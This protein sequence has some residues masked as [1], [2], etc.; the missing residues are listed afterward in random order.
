MRM[1]GADQ[2]TE[3]CA[4]TSATLWIGAISFEQRCLG[5]VMTLREAGAHVKA[6][7][8][9]D[10]STNMTPREIGE[11]RRQEHWLQMQGA[12]DGVIRGRFER[13]AVEPYSYSDIQRSLKE[14]TDKQQPDTVV[15]DVSCMTKIHALA[16]GSWLV[17]HCQSA[18]IIISYT[19]PLHFGNL[20]EM[21]RRM[22]W[23]DIVII[24][25]VDNAEL[26]NEYASRGIIVLGHE[27]DRL[28]VA[29][30]E[31]HP[32][33][34]TI[35][36]PWA[37]RRPDL[38]VVANRNNRK[39]VKELEG[40]GGGRWISREARLSEVDGLM[41]MVDREVGLAAK[42]EAPLIVFPFGPKLLLLAISYRLRQT[43]ERRTWL[44]YPVPTGYDV[45]YS[46]GIDTVRWMAIK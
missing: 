2:V 27:N 30:S 1:L 12:A 36:T 41:E 16:I 34:G 6:G 10:Y 38:R 35:V 17:T 40:L 5:G 26:M 11:V 7:I 28:I 22:G 18:N 37:P 46:E 23:K 19:S 14:V 20:V 3:M 4:A 25:L 9:I 31:M 21:D 42:K 8:A 33:G 24:P 45:E 15:I 43:Y 29:L 44:V 32:S 13:T 39:I